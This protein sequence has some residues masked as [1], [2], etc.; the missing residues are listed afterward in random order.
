MSSRGASIPPSPPM[1]GPGGACEIYIMG[2]RNPFRLSVDSRRRLLFW[3]EVGPDAGESDSARGPAGH[4][5]VNRARAAGFFGWPYFVG[6]NKPYRDYN[7]SAKTP[8]AVFDPTHPMNDSP[9]NTGARELPPAQAAMIW[10]PYGNSERF[11]LLGNGS[12]NAMAGPVY[13]C[14]QYPANTRLPDYYDSK[15]II[16]DW[17][18]GWMMAVTLDSLGNFS[19]MEPFADSIRLSRPMD[20]VVDKNGSIWVLEYGKQWFSSNPDARLSRIDYV[21]GNRPPIAMLHADKTAGASPCSVLF[22]AA[23]TKDYDSNRLTYTFDFGDDSPV[24][25]VAN[26]KITVAEGGLA[27]RNKPRPHAADSIWHTFQRAGTYTV[28]LKVTDPQGASATAKQTIRVGNAP[29]DI[30]WDL[31][32]RNRSFYEPGTVLHYQLQVSDPEDGALQNGEITPLAVVASID[33]LQT[34]FDIT[35]I[36]QGHQA[37][38]AQAEYSRGKILLDRS[39]CTACHATDRQVN[40]P[41]FQAIAGRYR[42][43]EFAVRDLARKIITG[44]AG[45]WGQTAMSAHPQLTESDAGEMVRWIISLGAPVKPAQA[46]DV[47]GTYLLAT[48]GS[49]K[50]KKTPAPGTYILKASYLDR[51]SPVQAPLRASETIA[52]R[53]AFQ[54]AEQADSISRHIRSYRPFS[55]D[56]VVL[57]ELKH[58]S[59]FVFKRCDLR[60]MFSVAINLGSGDSYYKMSGGRMELRLDSP[61]GR[62]VGAAPIAA[63]NSPG[64]MTFFE[65][66]LPVDQAAWP[67]DRTFHDLYF[68]AKNEKNPSEIVT[69]VDWV[70]FNL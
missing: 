54:Q 60:G 48:P 6:D 65:I 24:L 50:K 14:D 35:G 12:R 23:G 55:G 18:R 38:Q 10:Y 31:G 44:G 45:A 7:F 29:P 53:P 5:E 42:K 19:R 21:R 9:N 63:A 32:G 34:G 41:S 16:Y 39:D 1:G 67:D 17:M 61:G 26:N 33:Y 46:L 52:L 49:G 47:K 68:V 3:G 56:T 28:V 57:N 8:G 58:N 66:T 37:A 69:A 25:T 11:P 27:R 22:S 64:R 4:D 62:L 70:R 2:C 59:F 15:L 40:G 36:V 30:Y 43:N 20:M 51:G 13:Y